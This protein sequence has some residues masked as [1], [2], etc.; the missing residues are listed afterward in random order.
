MDSELIVR[1]L[2][3]RYRVRNPGLIPLHKRVLALRERFRR[4]TVVHVP[5]NLNKVADRLANDA[6]NRAGG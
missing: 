3:G 5:R 1:Q 2:W 6:L 4:V